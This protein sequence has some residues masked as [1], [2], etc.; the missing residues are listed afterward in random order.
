VVDGQ[1]WKG[2]RRH[3]SGFDR[4]CRLKVRGSMF[5]VRGSRFYGSAVD[6]FAER[7]GGDAAWLGVLIGAVF[8][9]DRVAAELPVE[10][11]ESAGVDLG[12]RL[13]VNA[14]FG[15]VDGNVDSCLESNWEKHWLLAVGK[16]S[17]A[18]DVDFKT[19]H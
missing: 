14:F 11:E 7:V 9:E 16:V 8:G 5:K 1:R 3:L 4:D 12:K 2:G 18:N 17:I 6:V 19:T 10:A 15:R 13:L